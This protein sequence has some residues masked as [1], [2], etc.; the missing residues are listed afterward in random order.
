MI[1]LAFIAGGAGMPNW[2][3][4]A[5]GETVIVVVIPLV[6]IRQFLATVV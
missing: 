3:V 2:D 1:L 5:T 6:G 4:V